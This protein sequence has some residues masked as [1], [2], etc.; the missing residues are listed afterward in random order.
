MSILSFL[1]LGEYG[2][3]AQVL[4]IISKKQNRDKKEAMGTFL[5][6]AKANCVEAAQV[7]LQP[8]GKSW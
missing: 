3:T 2:H 6:L 5:S 7:W 4:C 8:I 1:G